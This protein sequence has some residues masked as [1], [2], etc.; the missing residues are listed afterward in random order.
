MVFFHRVFLVPKGSKT[1]MALFHGQPL[2]SECLQTKNRKP[3]KGRT[4]KSGQ[5]EVGVFVASWLSVFC[6]VVTEYHRIMV[7]IAAQNLVPNIGVLVHLWEYCVL[8]L[9]P[10]TPQWKICTTHFSS[11]GPRYH[12]P[13]TDLGFFCSWRNKAESVYLNLKT[14]EKANRQTSYFD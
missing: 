2:V 12:G 13:F 3:A 6:F 10:V 7:W 14:N 11:W 1:V 9:G 4:W 5:F 8:L